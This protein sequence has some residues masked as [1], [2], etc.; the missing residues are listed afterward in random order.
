MQLFLNNET[1]AQLKITSDLLILFHNIMWAIIIFTAMIGI[2]FWFV[3]RKYRSQY[4]LENSPKPEFIPDLVS[5]GIEGGVFGSIKLLRFFIIYPFLAIIILIIFGPIAYY[6]LRINGLLAILFLDVIL[7]LRLNT[8]ALQTIN[9][10]GIK[11]NNYITTS[12][13]IENFEKIV[14]STTDF[15]M[16]KKKVHLIFIIITFDFLLYQ[17]ELFYIWA[18][19]MTLFYSSQYLNHLY[20]NKLLLN[21]PLLLN[22]EY[23]TG[24]T[25]NNLI[26]YQTTSLDY[27]F[28]RK[29]SI[30][31]I[32]IPATS[33]K[34]IQF[35]YDIQLNRLDEL[36]DIGQLRFEKLKLPSFIDK[37][38]LSKIGSKITEKKPKL[39]YDKATIYLKIDDL[40]NTEKSLRKAIELDKNIKDIAMNDVDLIKIQ[41]K[42]WFIDLIN[43]NAESD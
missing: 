27:R 20:L 8:I 41:S 16:H 28:K 12:I 21:P 10:E 14:I 31:E 35:N 18:I 19:L 5:K 24:E 34:S 32:I 25:E 36:L 3:H 39:W 1:Q 9:K 11:N 30:E 29:N 7:W 40:E 13:L 38:I 37:I 26:L 33:I 43:E 22:V 42:K 15:F 2:F 17:I 23:S 4:I 6:L